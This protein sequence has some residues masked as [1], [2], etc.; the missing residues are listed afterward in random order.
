M[1]TTDNLPHELYCRPREGEDEPRIES[2]TVARTDDRGRVISRPRI[3]RCVEC[4]SQT[5]QG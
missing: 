1:S 5:V 4:G 3:T 2:F